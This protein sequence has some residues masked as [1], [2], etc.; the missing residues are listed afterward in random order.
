MPSKQLEVA[1]D[2]GNSF[3]TVP[4]QLEVKFKRIQFRGS[5]RLFVCLMPTIRQNEAIIFS[6]QSYFFV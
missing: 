3:I 5:C 4:G 2:L 1:S 6:F